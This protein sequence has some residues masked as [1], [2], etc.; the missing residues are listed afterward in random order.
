[1]SDPCCCSHFL[2]C[3]KGAWIRTVCTSKNRTDGESGKGGAHM[4]NR[5]GDQNRHKSEDMDEDECRLTPFLHAKARHMNHRRHGH[6]SIPSASA[7]IT[8]QLV[9]WLIFD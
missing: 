3:G 8:V 6:F 5:L 7:S 1:M 4:A 2:L 9:L